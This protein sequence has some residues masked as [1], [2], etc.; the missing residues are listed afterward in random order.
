[1]SSN[2]HPFN[3][4]GFDQAQREILDDNNPV[5]LL[6]KVYQLW[7]HWADFHLFIVNP[8][9][10]AIS[11]PVII[12]PEVIG[13]SGELEFVYPIHDFGFKLS[14]SKGQEMYSAGMSMCKMY[15]TI[16][17]MIYLLIERLKSGGVDAETEVQV[18]FA[19][20]E[21]VKRK[22][23]ESTIN[24]D[25]NVIVTNFDP[26]KWGERYLKNVKTISARG[27]GFPSGAPRET[28][29]QIYGTSTSFKR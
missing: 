6:E 29:R 21:L 22:A 11:P 17:K 8:S 3:S 12:P 7:W 14:T 19:G 13:S 2:E 23:F 26:E 15:Y 16:E 4:F 24:L 9:I 18:A 5:A 20:H 27:L 25:Y 1:M 10:P 28:F